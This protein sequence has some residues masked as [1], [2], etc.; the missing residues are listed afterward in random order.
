MFFLLVNVVAVLLRR[1]MRLQVTEQLEAAAA[2]VAVEGPPHS[3]RE[4]DRVAMPPHVVFAGEALAADV[5]LEGPR[6]PVP[7]S[8]LSAFC[9]SGTESNRVL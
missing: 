8:R 6:F 2:V 7:R 4:M 1:V 5:A 9:T 3:D